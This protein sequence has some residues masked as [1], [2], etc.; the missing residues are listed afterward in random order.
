MHT[1]STILSVPIRVIRGQKIRVP[2][3]RILIPIAEKQQ[4]LFVFPK[5]AL[6]L[7]VKQLDNYEIP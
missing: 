3:A 4:D 7:H 2:S 1:V 5:K 6:Y